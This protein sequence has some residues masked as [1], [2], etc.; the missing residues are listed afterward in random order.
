MSIFI[1]AAVLALLLAIAGYAY[2]TQSIEKKRIQKQ[3]ILMTLKTKQRNLIHLINGFPP[4]FLTGE[5]LSLVYRALIDTCEQ[6]SKIEPK[7]QR[8]LDDI[9]LYNNQLDTLP[10]NNTAQRARV[11]NPQAMKEIR[12]HLQELQHFLVQQEALKIINKVQFGAYTDQVKRLSLQMAVDAYLYHAKLAQQANKLRLAIH[13]FTL[14]KKLLIAENTT[15]GYDKQ[16]AQL[17][18]ITAKLEEKAQLT[19][20]VSAPAEVATPDPTAKEWENFTP[21]DGDAWKKKQIYD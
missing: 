6:L 17:E 11:E 14:A 18:E 7:D 12:Q 15:R 5:L 19:G 21:P 9:T 13:Y 3:R 10:K 2:I 1:V 4:N 16:I 20:E 8:H